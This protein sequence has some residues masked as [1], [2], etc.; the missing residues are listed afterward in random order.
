MRR[1]R[2]RVDQLVE[3]PFA[4][5]SSDPDVLEILRRDAKGFIGLHEKFRLAATTSDFNASDVSSIVILEDWADLGL[6]G[7]W[8]VYE[9]GEIPEPSRYY[10]G[11]V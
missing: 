8:L 5:A 2:E 6:G 7:R 1:A 11:P 4:A 10:L 3:Q 9:G